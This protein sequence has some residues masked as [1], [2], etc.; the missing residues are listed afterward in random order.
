MATTYTIYPSDDGYINGNNANYATARGTSDAYDDS[1]TAL[2]VGQVISNFRVY[3]AFLA[4]DTSAIPLDTVLLDATISLTCAADA[5]TADFDLLIGQCEWLG[6]W[7]SNQEADYDAALGADIDV[8]MLNSAGISVGT[9]YTSPSLDLQWI[10][11]GGTTRYVLLSAEDV[12]NSQPVSNERLGFRSV[13]YATEAAR[14]YLTVTAGYRGIVHESDL[15]A[16]ELRC[17]RIVWRTRGVAI[18][19]AMNL[20]LNGMLVRIGYEHADSGVSGS[21][22]DVRLR[23]FMGGDVLNASGE[24]LSFNDADQLQPSIELSASD[25]RPI[26]CG[27][28]HVLEI[29]TGSDETH[30]VLDIYYAPYLDDR[31]ARQGIR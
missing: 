31:L 1:S 14:P 25:L 24:S 22:Y 13:E 12:N 7:A 3:R 26:L 9:K 17:R 11:R 27:G 4:F 5:T 16:G 18:S 21:E 30:G 29:D 19:H 6:T 28:Q 23:D 8:T 2:Y 20:P 10:R 15:S